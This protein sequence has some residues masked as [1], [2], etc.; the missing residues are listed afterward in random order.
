CQDL[1]VVRQRLERQETLL[2][3]IAAGM[4]RI[5]RF[6]LDAFQ[7]MSGQGYR[8]TL[9]DGDPALSVRA[10]RLPFGQAFG[11]ESPIGAP[12]GAPK[13]LAKEETIARALAAGRRLRS[14]GRKLTLKSVAEA[15]GLKYSQI[16]YAFGSKDEMLSRVMDEDV[17]VANAS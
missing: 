16:V 17:D 12:M 14:Q 4:R 13:R 3:E 10:E 11:D 1:E 9:D 5:D 2:N 7:R 8:H 6:T 15:A